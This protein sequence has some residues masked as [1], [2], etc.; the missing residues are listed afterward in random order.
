[1]FRDLIFLLNIVMLTLS[2]MAYSFAVS[3]AILYI[4]ELIPLCS[5]RVDEKSELDGLDVSQMGEF[6]F[7]ALTE[8]EVQWN[9][10]DMLVR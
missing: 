10:G 1:V 3:Y 5:L 6:A 8:K 9:L 2:I 4:M 7:E